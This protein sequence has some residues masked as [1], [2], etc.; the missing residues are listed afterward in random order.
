MKCIQTYTGADKARKNRFSIRKVTLHSCGL[1][2]QRFIKDTAKTSYKSHK[3][4]Y[5]TSH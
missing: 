5:S 1:K 2:S 4:L 3:E